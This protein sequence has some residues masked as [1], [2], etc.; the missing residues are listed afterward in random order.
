M[1]ELKCSEC[2]RYQERV[3]I[4]QY[5]AGFTREHA[6]RYARYDI[7]VGCSGTLGVGLFDK[8]EITEKSCE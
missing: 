5:D 8:R 2:Y 6:E 4:M 1:S 7:C 3:A